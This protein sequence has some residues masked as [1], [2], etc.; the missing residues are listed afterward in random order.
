MDSYCGN[1]AAIL[2]QCENSTETT[3]TEKLTSSEEEMIRSTEEYERAQFNKICQNSSDEQYEN[4]KKAKEA[5]SIRYIGKH[6]PNEF[7]EDFLAGQSTKN[8]TTF[9]NK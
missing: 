9:A 5:F 6:D 7:G 2:V 4:F 1:S 3:T 8:Y